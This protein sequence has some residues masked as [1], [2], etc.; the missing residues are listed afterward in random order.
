MAAFLSACSME[1]LPRETDPAG[2]VAR[3][4]PAGLPVYVACVPGEEYGRIIA[5]CAQ[6]RRAGFQPVPHL[7]ARGIP[8]EGALD[9]CL[10]Q[11]AGEAGVDRLLLLGGD[12]GDSKAGPYPSSLHIL[13]TGLLPRHGFRA[14]GF[15]TYPEPH[16][17]VTSAV[18]DRELR[19]KLAVARDAGLD[20]WLVSQFSYDADA[21]VRHAQRLRAD[22]IAAPLRVGVSGPASWAAMARFAL[23]CGFANSVRSLSQD[24]G[25]FGRLLS[26]FEPTAMLAALAERSAAEPALGLA[27]PHFFSF[28]GSDRTAKFIATLTA[29]QEG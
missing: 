22:G 16:P 17:N 6:L 24:A 18:L 29:S 7:P 5:L 13:R 9:G 10:G 23:I 3:H 19:L 21:V 27:G 25:R 4:L 20:G 28:G 15:A 14:V 12:V 2:A 26:G 8:S 1:V 11:L